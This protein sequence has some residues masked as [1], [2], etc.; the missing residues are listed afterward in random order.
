M[1]KS[2]TIV[3]SAM[4]LLVLTTSSANGQ[5][6]T[7]TIPLQPGWNAVFLEVQPEPDQCESVFQGLP[8][9]SVSPRFATLTTYG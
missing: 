4:V 6:I 1:P 7:Q 3:F 5:W 9:E 2:R 8:V